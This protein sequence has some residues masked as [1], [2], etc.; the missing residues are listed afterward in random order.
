MPSSQKLDAAKM[1]M[2][3]QAAAKILRCYPDH[4]GRE[5]PEGYVLSLT[6]ALAHQSVPMLAA[7]VS[8]TDGVPARCR[9]LP[10]VGDIHKVAHEIAERWARARKIRLP[11]MEE[12]EP[13]RGDVLKNILKWK[14]LRTEI[15]ERI[16]ESKQ[17]KW[18]VP[19]PENYAPRDHSELRIAPVRAS[20]ELIELLKASGYQHIK[21]TV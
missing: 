8:V 3:R 19:T 14:T 11:P 10:T 5:L 9:F 20:K 15:Q 2:G 6:E 18:D 16:D 21:E 4:S 12:P 7:L 13:D 1:E 17:S